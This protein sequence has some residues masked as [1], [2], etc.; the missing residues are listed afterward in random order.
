MRDFPRKLALIAAALLLAMCTFEPVGD[1]ASA[2]LGDEKPGVPEGP[3]HRPGQ[4]CLVCHADDYS[5]AG[6]I[7]AVK[8]DTVGVAGASVLLS[9]RDGKSITLTTNA[10]GNFFV[11]K[12]AW[13]PTYPIQTSVTIGSFTSTM[14]S[15]IGRNGSCASCHVE[16][17]SRVSAGAVYVAPDRALLP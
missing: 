8:G 12:D 3:T 4:P 2:D 13:N 7:Y 11:S 17:A 10:A 15:I 1:E 6:T 16:P 5:A 14:S 9:D